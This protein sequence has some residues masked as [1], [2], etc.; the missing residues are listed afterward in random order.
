MVV[1]RTQSN[2][3]HSGLLE[4]CFPSTIQLPL[5][6]PL[7]CSPA[8]PCSKSSSLPGPE[9]RNNLLWRCSPA[10]LRLKNLQRRA[11][12]YGRQHRMA[13]WLLQH[14]PLDLTQESGQLPQ[15][16]LVRRSPGLAIRRRP[17][18]FFERGDGAGMMSAVDKMRDSSEPDLLHG[19]WLGLVALELEGVAVWHERALGDDLCVATVAVRYHVA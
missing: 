10:V 7:P 19:S 3:S 6:L 9:P 13:V 17:V 2:P 15:R 14:H 1:S 5:P 8:S 11:S 12:L 16:H 18:H 4:V